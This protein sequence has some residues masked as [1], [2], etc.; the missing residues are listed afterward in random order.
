MYAALNQRNGGSPAPHHPAR[1]LKSGCIL[2]QDGPAPSFF[3]SV[4]KAEASHEVFASQLRDS[5]SNHNMLFRYNPSGI[6]HHIRQYMDTEDPYMDAMVEA[7]AIG[8]ELSKAAFFHF[9]KEIK[10]CV[11]VDTMDALVRRI[12]CKR[13]FETD[14][15]CI[16]TISNIIFSVDRGDRRR[17]G[18]CYFSVLRC[19]E[20][21]ERNGT[22]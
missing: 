16:F 10:R 18:P 17:C 4:K 21:D 1:P 11:Y 3:D 22:L 5:I 6:Y 12:I 19:H 2:K 9:S 15:S 20:R 14:L 8:V 7:S 13:N